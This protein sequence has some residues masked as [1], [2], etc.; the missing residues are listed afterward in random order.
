MY[1]RLVMIFC[2]ST[3]VLAC[4]PSEQNGVSTAKFYDNGTHITLH[5]SHILGIKSTLYQPSFELSGTIQPSQEQFI[6]SPSSG[7]LIWLFVQ[8]HQ[9]VQKNDKLAIIKP[10]WHPEKNASP[11]KP[12]T[13]KAPF[14]GVVEQLFVKENAYTADNQPLMI[15]SD[16]HHF[17][18]ISTLP[19]K[20]GNKLRIGQSVNLTT[21]RHKDGDNIQTFSGQVAHI[22][23][24]SNDIIPDSLTVNVHILPDK[25]HQRAKGMRASGRIYDDDLS[26]GALIPQHALIKAEHVESLKEPPYQPPLPLPAQVWVIRQDG[27]LNLTDILVIGYQPDT[28]KF[29]V[30]GISQDSLIAAAPLP[31]SANGKYVNIY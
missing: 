5:K 13:I 25:D 26:V 28:Q 1:L 22:S 12:I 16:N 21:A 14:D 10:T 11:P 23:A 29:L 4:Q 30:S 3:V 15:L 7:T 24:D 9:A 27:T 8:K 20:Y 19:G 18:L 17:E 31:M 6:H 2:L